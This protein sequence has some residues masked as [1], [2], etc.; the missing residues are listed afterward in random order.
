MSWLRWWTGTVNDPKWR[1]VA[2][3]AKCRPG[4][5]V[6]VWAFLLEIA[7]DADG[8]VS[9]ADAE[10]C[11]VVLGYEVEVVEAIIAAMRDK[12]LIEGSRL[13]SWDKRQPKREDD[14]R[15]RVAAY[16]ERRAEEKSV[17][18]QRTYAR[19]EDVTHCNAPETEADTDTENKIETSS[20][21]GGRADT[22][23]R[24]P[25]R[26]EDFWQAYPKRDGSNPKEPAR[27][28]FV[29]AVKS[30]ADAGA[31][32]DG[33]KAYSAA[34]AKRGNVGSPYIAQAVTWLTQ[35][36]WQ[37]ASADASSVAPAARD[38]PPT[39]V[40]INP[41]ADPDEW[42]AWERHKGRKLPLDKQGGWQ[43]PSRMPPTETQGT[44]Q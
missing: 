1:M 28:R 17:T 31:I 12:K 33:A 9:K 5:C 8:D 42:A 11:A 4:D 38:G 14:S 24:Q 19:N 22:P 21:S 2:A 10:E 40:R 25:D 16:R 15:A 20:L 36:R 18:H 23:P 43:V 7:K 3:R 29:A 37:D 39:M 34:E 35:R 32:I 41:I 6:A 30:G 13:P 26:F 44:M 27:K